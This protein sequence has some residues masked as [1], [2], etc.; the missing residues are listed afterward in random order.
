MLVIFRIN[1][2][3]KESRALQCKLATMS[4]I[5]HLSLEN[6]MMILIIGVIDTGYSLIDTEKIKQVSV[7]KKRRDLFGTIQKI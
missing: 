3:N 6:K 2:Q 7:V 4:N 5:D 1:Y